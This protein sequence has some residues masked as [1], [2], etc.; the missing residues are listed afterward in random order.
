VQGVE[1]THDGMVHV[2]ASQN[3]FVASIGAAFNENEV[4]L[5]FLPLAHIF[6]R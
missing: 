2:I 1:I 3:A 5:S 6:D 4:Y